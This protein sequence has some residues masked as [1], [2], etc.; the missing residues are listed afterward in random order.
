MK[1]INTSFKGI[2]YIESE[3]KR[4]VDADE[5][6]LKHTQ[7]SMNEIINKNMSNICNDFLRL[8]DNIENLEEV[9]DK[10]ECILFTKNLIAIEVIIIFENEENGIREYS[11]MENSN[12]RLD[13]KFPFIQKLYEEN[14]SGVAIFA[15]EPEIVLLKANNT[16]LNF[17]D[18]P[19]NKKSNAIGKR[20]YEFVS[21]WKGSKSEKIWKDILTTG[22]SF[23]IDEY[24][25]DRFDRG[26]TYW[27]GKLI[28]I[29][30]NR[31]IKYVIETTEE[32]TENVVNRIRI[33]E[34]NKKLKNLLIIKENFFSSMSHELKTPL[35]VILATTQLL[36]SI[37]KESNHNQS[38]DKYIKIM[39]QNCYRLLKLINNLIDINK[40][41]SGFLKI[42][43]R[44]YNLVE[45]VENI[46][47]SIVEYV[48]SH[49]LDIVFDTDIEEKIMAFDAEKI[50]RVVLNLL[51]NAVK[52]TNENGQIL[53]NIYD[54]GEKIIISIKDNGIGI[55]AEMLKEI[56]KR[57]KQV[58]SPITRRPEGSGIGLSLVKSIIELH[59]GNIRVESEYGKGSE[60]IIELPV[61]M[62][63]DKPEIQDEVAVT[64]E[65]NVERLHIEFSD[66]YL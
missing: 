39:K 45:V 8:T 41:D 38:V 13:D 34:Q 31:R 42:E 18:T 46:T 50:E 33:E 6:F 32:I 47:L 21:G 1:F 57:F 55:P 40:L 63:E 65:T 35:N 7:Y 59:N 54:K 66:I 64:S 19:F 60:F 16:F 22:E 3:C 23:S 15:I 26:T 30:E 4:L 48:K 27:K 20:I 43:K 14:L 53:V 17:F 37:K 9:G 24:K 61:T 36:N 11:C 10:I 5:D 29:F 62:V 52:F 58:D 28:P 25:Y 12:S 51:S 56:F 2:F 44:N 49:K